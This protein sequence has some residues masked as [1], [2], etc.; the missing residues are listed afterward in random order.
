MNSLHRGARYLAC[1][2]WNQIKNYC[3]KFPFDVSIRE[4]VTPKVRELW[5]V[6]SSDDAGV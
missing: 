3:A 1:L 4:L 5:P 2:M 6:E